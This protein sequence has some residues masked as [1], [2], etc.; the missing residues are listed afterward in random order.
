MS[1]VLSIV[2]L[3]MCGHLGQAQ[4]EL[5]YG[6][7]M[8]STKVLH[9]EIDRLLQEIS[10]TQLIDNYSSPQKRTPYLSLPDG[11]PTAFFCRL[12][13][14]QEQNGGRKTR[15]RLGSVEQTNY[16]EGKSAMP[17]QL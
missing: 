6:S 10:S 11:S 9:A 14:R 13:H 5:N 15:F 7:T 8:S 17:H 2:L 12:E 1:K 4:I 3:M 16:L